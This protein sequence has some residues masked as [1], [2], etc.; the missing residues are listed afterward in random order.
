MVEYAVEYSVANS[1]QQRRLKIINIG[2]FNQLQISKIGIF[3]QECIEEVAS[4]YKEKLV[5]LSE[6]NSF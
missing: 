4:K 5:L 3:N 2:I 1:W 6:L